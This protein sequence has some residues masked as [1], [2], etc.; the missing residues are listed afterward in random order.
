MLRPPVGVAILGFF[1]LLAGIAYLVVGLRLT[2]WVVF[3]PGSIGDG[4][5]FWG[6][7]TDRRRDRLRGRG[8]RRS[9]RSSRGPGCSA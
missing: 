9:G 8:V 3:G 6:L 1:S 5:F 4:T 7:L 2:G